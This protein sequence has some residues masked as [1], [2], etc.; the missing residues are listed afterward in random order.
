MM[1][2]CCPAWVAYVEFNHPELIP[3][4]TSA[5]S[6]QAHIAG[7]VKSYWAKMNNINP[8]SIAVVSIVPCTAK[9]YESTRSELNLNG[10]PIVDYVLTTREFAYLLKKHNIDLPKLKPSET[11][12]LFNDGSGAAAIYGTSGGVMESALRTANS[13]VCKNKQNKKICNSRLEFKEVRGLTGF[14]EATINLNGRKIKVGVVNG[15]GH[16]KALLPKLN[17]YHYIEV[18][19]CPGGCLGGGGQP[20]STS[21][22]VRK[23]RSEGMYKIDTNK[24]VRKAHENKAMLDYYSWVKENKLEKKLLH[25]K[26]KKSSGSILKVIDPRKKSL[27]KIFTS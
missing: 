27:L 24:K 11:D 18:M 10:Q 3:N 22:D 21:K 13:F 6:P 26:F 25:T 4:L 20:L 12:H 16:F 15:L 5:R 17:K 8:K 2:S 1:T 14:K 23:M 9:K 7:A 19:A